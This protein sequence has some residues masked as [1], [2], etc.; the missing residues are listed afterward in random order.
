MLV[1]TKNHFSPYRYSTISVKV[2]KKKSG[3]VL[4]IFKNYFLSVIE[5]LI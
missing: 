5:A 4:I 1:F 3:I 2:K